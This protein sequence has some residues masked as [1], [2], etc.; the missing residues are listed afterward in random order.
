MLNLNSHEFHL[1]SLANIVFR[2]NQLR[3]MFNDEF[4]TLID[5]FHMVECWIDHHRSNFT[6]IPIRTNTSFQFSISNFNVFPYRYKDEHEFQ[7]QSNDF[8]LNF[9]WGHQ[10]LR[11]DIQFCMNSAR[12]PPN[13][14]R[15][16]GF[17]QEICM[18]QPK[19]SSFSSFD[20]SF[21]I[22]PKQTFCIQFQTLNLLALVAKTSLSMLSNAKFEPIDKTSS[23]IKV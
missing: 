20:S 2:S 6:L 13:L 14:L 12:Y 1:Q 4:Q 11:S 3:L 5:D 17:D 15:N 7:T 8:E 19:L 9:T 16:I 18:Y 10:K 21:C 23:N 22:P